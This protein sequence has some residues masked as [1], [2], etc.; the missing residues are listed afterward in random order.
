MAVFRSGRIPHFC[1][2][3]NKTLRRGVENYFSRT[4]KEFLLHCSPCGDKRLS[5]CEW[6][7]R[8]CSVPLRLSPVTP[9]EGRG[10]GYV[11][12]RTGQAL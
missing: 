12:G 11:R 4:F 2:L 6:S 8:E 9:E 10:R 3:P 1:G 7:G 5:G